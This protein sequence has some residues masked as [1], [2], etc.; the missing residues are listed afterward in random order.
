MPSSGSGTGTPV[1]CGIVPTI[2]PDAPQ[3]TCLSLARYAKLTNYN[4]CS[5]FGVK[6]DQDTACFHI[7]SQ[8]DRD[9]IRYYL[10][11]ALEEIENILRYPLCPTWFTDEVHQSQYPQLTDWKKVIAGGIRGETT[12]AAG[13]GLDYTSEPVGIG[14]IAT[15]LTDTDEIR[16]FYPGSD[17]EIEPSIV[18]ISG[19]Q[20][21]IFIPRCRLV[22]PDLWDDQPAG[23]FDYDDLANF[24]GAVD[25]RRVYND[26][27]VQGEIVWPHGN[28]SCPSCSEGVASACLTVKDG[29]IGEVGILPAT[30]SSGS[31]SSSSWS[32]YSCTP[33][34]MRLNYYAGAIP[35]PLTGENSIL[36]LA[37]T[38]MPSQPC[39]GCDY[40]RSIWGRD[41]VIPDLITRERA[42]NPFGLMNGAW[43]AWR[44][45]QAIRKVRLFSL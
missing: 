17:Y 35:T 2:I 43:I 22:N 40:T 27:S 14:P 19:G 3:R 7:M 24:T 39:A 41:R 38:K 32:C 4:E 5:L 42:N 29:E 18:Q 20:L 28:G 36:R 26:T 10:A 16:V 23:G 8:F 31:W 6:H 11:E 45:T 25:V 1:T 33:E 15:T 37:H 34:K 9:N 21:T 12:I 44:F 30:Y 13:E